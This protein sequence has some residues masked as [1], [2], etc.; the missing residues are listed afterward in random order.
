M[1][2]RAIAKWIR[3]SPQKLRRQADMVRGRPLNEVVAILMLSPS[4]AARRVLRVVESAAAN[5]E[6]NYG[7]E[8]DDLVLKHIAVDKA[9]RFP[10]RGRPRARGRM[11]MRRKLTSHVTVV[12]SDEEGEE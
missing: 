5:A 2:A 9:L 11:D 3:C 12:L 10:V 6:N 7:L 4:P 1:E 8:P